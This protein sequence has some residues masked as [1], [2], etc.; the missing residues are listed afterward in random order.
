MSQS[1]LHTLDRDSGWPSHG[2]DLTDRQ[3]AVFAIVAHL[4][5]L[6]MSGWTHTLLSWLA[7]YDGF[8]DQMPDG[9][10]P[11]V[12]LRELLA[13]YIAQ[14]GAPEVTR[15]A[16]DLC[17]MPFLFHRA[18]WIRETPT[19]TTRRDWMPLSRAWLDFVKDQSPGEELR[20]WTA[21]VAYPPADDVRDYLLQRYAAQIDSRRLPP[22]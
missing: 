8:E 7:H 5:S 10:D 2:R 16:L 14:G 13:R 19:Q 22:P 21:S 17:S 1:P 18:A 4:E 6:G 20:V 11:V 12:C 15:V 9:D 3:H